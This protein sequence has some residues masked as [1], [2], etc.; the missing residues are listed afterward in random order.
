MGFFS[1]RRLTLLRDVETLGAVGIVIPAS[2]ELAQNGVV[3]AKS[4]WRREGAQ[5]AVNA[6]VPEERAE[7]GR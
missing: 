2:E 1:F 3:T 5:A 4:K 7:D 6:S